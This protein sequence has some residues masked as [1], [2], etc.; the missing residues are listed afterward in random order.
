[1]IATRRLT[2]VSRRRIK[3]NGD[4][5]MMRRY[6]EMFLERAEGLPHLEEQVRTAE[7]MVDK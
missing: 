1:M 5:L 7:Q 2:I 4:P 3:K 6:L